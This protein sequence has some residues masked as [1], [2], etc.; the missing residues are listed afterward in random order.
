MNGVLTIGTLD[1][2]NV[3]IREEVG[4]ENSFSGLTARKFTTCKPGIPSLEYYYANPRLQ[5]AIGRLDVRSF[6]AVMETS[7]DPWWIHSCS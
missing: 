6:P 7:S 4:V 3:E 5:G 1:G 2:A